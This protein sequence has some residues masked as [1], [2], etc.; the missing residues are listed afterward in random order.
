MV[1][2]KTSKLWRFLSGFHPSLAGLVDIGRDGLESYADVVGHAIRQESLMKT[3][4]NVN[5]TTSER[6]KEVLQLSLLQVV[7]NQQSGRRF[8]FQTRKPNNQDRSG[9]SGGKPQIGGKRKSG[10]GNQGR[11]EQFGGSKRAR[12]NFEQWS[13]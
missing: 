9:G 2:I 1:Q 10:P 13:L 4:K 3:E 11:P 6:L 8:R 5:V 7:G 12:R